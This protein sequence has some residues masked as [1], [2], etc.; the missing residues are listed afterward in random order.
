MPSPTLPRPNID[1]TELERA[2]W[3]RGMLEELAVV[4]MTLAKDIAIRSMDSPYHP[5]LKHDPGRSFAGAARAVRLS[6][7]L[8]ART[9]E[10]IVALRNRTSLAPAGARTSST[11]GGRSVVEQARG[12][13]DRETDDRED[14]DPVRER[15][16][17]YLIE[18]EDDDERLAD[19]FDVCVATIRADLG[20]L[21]PAT[22]VSPRP[23]HLGAALRTT[24]TSSLPQSREYGLAA[25]SRE[26]DGGISPRP[27]PSPE[28]HPP[29]RSPGYGPPQQGT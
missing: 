28:H 12:S 4:G 19:D 14:T 22:A 23:H 15:E 21:E 8:A 29:P 11:S 17:E 6:L 1:A 13:T 27:P 25:S 16:R 2:E 26:R 7:I 9:D 20:M 3:R 5:E 24:R 18:R 10:Q